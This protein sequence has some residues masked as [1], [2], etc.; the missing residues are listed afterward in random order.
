MIISDKGVEKVI[1]FKLDKTEKQNFNNSVKSV[2]NL[3]EAAKKI[4]K[5]LK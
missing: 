2:Q 4:D 5:E 3:F 1:E